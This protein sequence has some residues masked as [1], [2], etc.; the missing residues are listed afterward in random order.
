MIEFIRRN[1][2]RQW[3][4]KT[5]LGKVQG[6]MEAPS[7]FLYSGFA[8][9]NIQRRLN[10]SRLPQFLRHNIRHP[11]GHLFPPVIAAVIGS[12]ALT[13]APALFE[14]NGL[15]LIIRL[16]QFPG[17]LIIEFLQLLQYRIISHLSVPANDLISFVHL[18][19]ES[20]PQP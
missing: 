16:L 2:Q 4:L 12:Y 18:G 14:H 8:V 17:L 5:C 1:I 9:F 3:F 11:S 20:L 13:H 6:G 19:L 15:S 10:N 7:T